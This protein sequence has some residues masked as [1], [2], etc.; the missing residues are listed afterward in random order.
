[1]ED[2]TTTVPTPLE[3]LIVVVIWDMN[4]IKVDVN[5]MVSECTKFVYIC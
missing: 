5:A 3:V 1:M 2:V 4:W